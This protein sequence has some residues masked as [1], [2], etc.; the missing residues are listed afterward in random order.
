MDLR[1]VEVGPIVES[2]AEALTPTAEAKGVRLDVTLD[3]ARVLVSGDPDRLRQIVW[4][5]LTNA[6]KFTP[7]EGRID[8]RLERDGSHARFVVADTGTGIEPAFLPC[9]FERFSLGDP[10]T[11]R[12]QGGL[13]LGLALTRKLVELHGGTITADSPGP[14][15]G[16]TFTVTAPILAVHNRPLHLRHVEPLSESASGFHFQP[17]LA[18]LHLLVVEDE[19]DAR[20]LIAVVLRQ[21]GAEVVAVGSVSEALEAL[22]RQVPDVLVSD[23]G[24]PGENGYDLIRKIRERENAHGRH[25]PAA[26][27]TCY[28]RDED[29]RRSLSAGFQLHVV[30]PVEPEELTRTVAKLAGRVA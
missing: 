6:L 30:K 23:I 7:A 26:A 4:N 12:Q 20:E 5:L 3:E 28:A 8:V 16:S 18:G 25:I 22:D 29:R 1:P 2:V 9:V 24:L 17:M 13:G 27:L 14:N 11:T 21:C 10:S 19:P 15:Q